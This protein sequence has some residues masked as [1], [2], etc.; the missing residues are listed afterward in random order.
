MFKESINGIV[1]LLM[2]LCY[3]SATMLGTLCIISHLVF[4][5]LVQRR[6][7]QSHSAGKDMEP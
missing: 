7:C 4:V 3:V 2:S 6:H 1:T 5:N